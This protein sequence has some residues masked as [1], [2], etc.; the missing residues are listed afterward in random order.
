MNSLLRILALPF[1]FLYWLI[2]AT[3]N[4]FFSLGIL[5]TKQYP[6]PLICIGNLSVGGTGK[7]PHL[8]Y[9]IELLQNHYRLASLSRGYGRSTKGFIL[10]DSSSSAKDIGDEPYQLFQKFDKLQVAVSESRVKGIEE[11]LQTNPSPEIILMDDAFQHRYVK[12]D[13]SILITEYDK[14]YIKDYI[15]P[16]GTLRESRSG[17]HR[18]DIIIVSKCPKSLTPL[19]MRS[20]TM[21]LN[22]QDYQKVFYSFIEYQKLKPLNQAALKADVSLKQLSAVD[23]CLLCALAKPEKLISFLKKK[24]QQLD[25][26]KYPDHYY[27]RVKDYDIIKKKFTN[28]T[29]AKILICT[30]KDASKLKL[31]ELEDIPVFTL[32][33]KIQFHQ[34]GEESL[35]TEILNYV[36]TYTRSK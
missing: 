26:L 13:M 9:L 11:L 19:E 17:A 7:T 30:E 28:L 6:F 23:V 32:P 21:D 34:S 25:V 8:E 22:L 4:L 15:M 36:R 1:A 18:A 12:A 10:A 16:A 14:P 24:N 27:F 29:K 2:T 31:E 20:F 5:K 3:R 35:D 33:I